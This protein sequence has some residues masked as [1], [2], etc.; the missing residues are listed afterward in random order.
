[1]EN[2]PMEW[3]CGIDERI[4]GFHERVQRVPRRIGARLVDMHVRGNRF[5]RE[6][7]YALEWMTVDD[8]L[9]LVR[10]GC[11]H[12]SDEEGL[13][14]AAATRA[15]KCIGEL[16]RLL[17]GG[18]IVVLLETYLRR[19]ATPARRGVEGH[20]RMTRRS[21]SVQRSPRYADRVGLNFHALV[22]WRPV[23]GF[24]NH[25]YLVLA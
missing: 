10:R 20:Q 8:Q 19:A 17:D 7:L 13:G 25:A 22:G 9:H 21:R 14:R 16:P 1:M 15:G 3:Q 12:A 2:V 5:G 24:E 23:G 6:S 11:L 4:N 18:G